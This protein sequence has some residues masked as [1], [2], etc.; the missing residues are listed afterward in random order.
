MKVPNWGD[1]D[2]KD[3]VTAVSQKVL[4]ILCFSTDGTVVGCACLCSADEECKFTSVTFGMKLMPTEFG[5][6]ETEFTLLFGSKRQTLGMFNNA[7]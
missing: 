1:V 5:F 2:V 7:Q 6:G 3:I 4:R